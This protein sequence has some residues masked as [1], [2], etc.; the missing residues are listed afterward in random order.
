M[1][2]T[3]VHNSTAP[4]HA[5]SGKIRTA[6]YRPRSKG[7]ARQEGLDYSLIFIVLFM[8]AFGLVMLYSASSYE[9][10][11][12]YGDTA[13]YL[14]R[15]AIFIA[16]GLVFMVGV[17][18]VPIKW[19][20]K[21][22]GLVYAFSILLLFL[23][24]PFGTTANGATRWIY[25]G[26]VSIQPAEVSKLAVIVLTAALISRM[27][28]DFLQ[29]W[30]G[31]FLIL[32]PSI[33]EAG[34][35]YG[36]SSNLSSAI[37]VVLIAAAML[38]VSYDKVRRFVVIGIIGIAA[39]VLII[40]LVT[41]TDLLGSY[42]AERIRAWLDPT[43]YSDSTALQTL[44]GLYGI[45]SGGIFGKGLGQSIQKLGYI[46]EAQNDMIFSIIC[47]E[48]GLFG[49][50]SIIMMFLMLGW[51]ILLVARN[52]GSLFQSFVVVGV[53]AHLMIQVMLNIAVV[54]N[55]MPNT[56]VTLP[57]FSYGGSAILII[58]VEMGLV[59]NVSR[60]TAKRR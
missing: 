7:S 39:V 34:L 60:N 20:K 21:F 56:G 3:K 37:I 49:A 48:L 29:S 38:F 51:R 22:S 33:L 12:E 36:I 57:F 23:L 40:F 43:A 4:Q 52:A 53:L 28:D 35:I 8:L 44:Q 17:M 50:I 45:G 26:P 27:P 19:W 5:R 58:L 41:N 30:K 10:G 31:F 11:V 47:E 54:T 59:L 18:Y 25:I 14:K 6:E 13:Y 1:A 46:P 24:I 32:A 42:Q 55:T 16:I 9:A 15:Q 2:N